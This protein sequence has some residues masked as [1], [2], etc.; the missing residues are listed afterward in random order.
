LKYNLGF[1]RPRLAYDDLAFFRNYY[2]TQIEMLTPPAMFPLGSRSKLQKSIITPNDIIVCFQPSALN[3]LTPLKQRYMWIHEFGHVLTAKLSPSQ[4]KRWVDVYYPSQ[5]KL[6]SEY[7]RT[8][9]T[10]GFAE[11]F[12]LFI[13]RGNNSTPAINKYF[14]DL[15]KEWNL[16]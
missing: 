9:P 11:E 14:K 16:L 15:Q 3:K 12:W 7:G 6:R 1:S 10:E 4:W 8:S 13:S 5:L 2:L